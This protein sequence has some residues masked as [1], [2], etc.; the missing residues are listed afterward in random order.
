MK[1]NKALTKFANFSNL[2]NHNDKYLIRFNKLKIHKYLINILFFSVIII[3][4]KQ[5]QQI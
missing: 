1:I 3:S 4:T 5:S 2:L